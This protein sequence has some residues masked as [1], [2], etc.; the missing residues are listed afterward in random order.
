[1]R[2]R[3]VEKVP[4]ARVQAPAVCARRGRAQGAEDALAVQQTMRAPRALAGVGGRQDAASKETSVEAWT[5]SW[6]F[7]SERVAQVAAAMREAQWKIDEKSQQARDRGRAR[8]EPERG[9]DDRYDV[10][11]EV[12]RRRAR[13][14]TSNTSSRGPAGSRR[15]SCARRASSTRSS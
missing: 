10:A 2:E 8:A 12:V 15:T 6:Q 13:R 7:I 5:A 1:V 9:L 4:S 11:A 14:S 3:A